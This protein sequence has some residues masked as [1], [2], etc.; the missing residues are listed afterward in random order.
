MGDVVNLNQFRKERDRRRKAVQAA[1]NRERFGRTKAEKEQ[2]RDE[3]SRIERL[4]DNTKRD[5]SPDSE[6]K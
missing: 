4:L 3:V 1:I 5:V 6:T 2:D